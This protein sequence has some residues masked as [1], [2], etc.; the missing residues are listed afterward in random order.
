MRWFSDTAAEVG[1]EDVVEAPGTADE[2]TQWH[3]EATTASKAGDLA[4]AATLY[5]KALRARVALFGAESEETD[6]TRHS[7]AATV[8]EQ[9]FNADWKEK[10]V[11]EDKMKWIMSAGFDEEEDYAVGPIGGMG[12][13]DGMGGMG[14]MGDMDMEEMMKQFDMSEGGDPTGPSGSD[15]LLD[16][17]FSNVTDPDA[18]EGASKIMDNLREQGWKPK[19]E[20]E[21]GFA[22]PEGLEEVAKAKA[23]DVPLDGP[24][25]PPPPLPGATPSDADSK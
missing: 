11:M 5:E 6:R 19:D 7:F 25:L 14:G 2:A 20:R 12:G 17:D 4:K 13:M 15:G 10:G 18:L 23:A 16:A 21:E 8:E 22:M 9:L 3:A 24:P 1:E